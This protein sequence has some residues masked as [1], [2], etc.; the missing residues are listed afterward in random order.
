M[1]M[2][3]ASEREVAPRRAKAALRWAFTQS[4]P[5]PISGAISL[6]LRPLAT[7]FRMSICREVRSTSGPAA[8]SRR[9]RTGWRR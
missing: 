7:Y 1:A 8:F 4:V 9:P 5:T 6:L 2:A 3:T